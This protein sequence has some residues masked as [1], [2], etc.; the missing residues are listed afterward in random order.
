MNRPCDTCAFGKDGAANEPDNQMVSTLA[1][2]GAIPFWCHHGRDGV[3]YDWANDPLGPMRLPAENR[4]VCA[5]W[6]GQVRNLKKRGFYNFLPI[7][8]AV[9]QR[10]MGLYKRLIIPGI[11]RTKQK[12]TL[13]A[14]KRCLKFLGT[15]DIEKEP[16]PL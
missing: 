8:R 16:V 13:R 2:A 10:A 15:R 3:E 7:R 9:A 5:G 6:Q 11:G 1:V 12:I 4:K 14:L